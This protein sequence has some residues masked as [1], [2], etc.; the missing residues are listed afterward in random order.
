MRKLTNDEL[1]DELKYLIDG[2]DIPRSFEMAIWTLIGW[3]R[4]RAGLK[5]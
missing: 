4:N 5:K 2:K 3:L 1:A